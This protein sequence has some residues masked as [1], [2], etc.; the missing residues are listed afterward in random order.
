[1]INLFIVTHL[2][3]FIHLARGSGIS[4]EKGIYRVF[5]KAPAVIIMGG[6]M[7]LYTSSW[8]FSLIYFLNFY[9]VL[10]LGTGF[11]M[12]AFKEQGGIDLIENKDEYKPIDTILDLYFGKINTEA[13]ARRYSVWMGTIYG[14]LAYISF[15]LYSANLNW[16]FMPLLLGIP[17]LG[18]GLLAGAMRYI[19]KTNVWGIVEY[20]WAATY[21]L[22][23][24][25][26][27]SI[28]YV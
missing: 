12:I 13:D 25:L 6:L 20:S 15:I 24:A 8:Q 7:Y 21:T 3:G 10:L 22:M 1:M 14:L 27:W 18:Y 11:L 28:C 9:L 17:V 16:N 26:T 4:K 23:S 19:K 2:A 5:S